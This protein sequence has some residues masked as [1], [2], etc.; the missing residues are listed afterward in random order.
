MNS[1]EVST[2]GLS[3]RAQELSKN[4]ALQK[5]EIEKIRRRK[6]RGN[7]EI[8]GCLLVILFVL[9]IYALTLLFDSQSRGHAM[10]RKQVEPTIPEVVVARKNIETQSVAPLTEEVAEEEVKQD[11]QEE[12]VV[13][14]PVQTQVVY[15]QN[16]PMPKAHQEYLYKL[17]N[18]YGLD[19][20]KTLALIKH[21]SGFEVNIVSDT[22]DYGYFQVN[23][24]NHEDLSR[25]LGT[26][27]APLDP[28]I[29]MRWGTYMLA[30]LYMYWGERGYSGQGLDDAVWSSY[31]KG[32]GGFKK[33]GHATEYIHKMKGSIAFIH[34]QY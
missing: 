5:R 26:A 4:K 1:T 20:M 11:K 16:I 25:T 31:N 6:N 17:T 3:Q 18:E 21:E 19:F 13:E 2:Q 7:K 28:Y 9:A 34:E 15:N 14:A 8:I 10:E 30:D 24:I 33:Y 12:V 22:N 23:L 27:N 29:N 32:L